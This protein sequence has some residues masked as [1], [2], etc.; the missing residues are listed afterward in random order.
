MKMHQYRETQ[1][2]VLLTKKLKWVVKAHSSSSFLGK[3]GELD[4]QAESFF[5]KK[6]GN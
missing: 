3:G 1:Q 5:L 4:F 2:Q 6:K